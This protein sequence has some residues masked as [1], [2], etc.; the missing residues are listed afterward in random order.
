MIY[1]EILVVK[2]ERSPVIVTNDFL[3]L[4]SLYY[5]TLFEISVDYIYHLSL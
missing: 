5:Y 4:Y 1:D 3:R 2:K